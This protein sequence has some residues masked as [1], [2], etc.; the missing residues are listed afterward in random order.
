MENMWLTILL[1]WPLAVLIAALLNMLITW[2]FSWS[3][4]VLDY[5]AGVV[6]GLFF[7]FGLRGDAGIISE[8][9]LVLSTGLFGFLAAL[10]V[11]ALTRPLTLFFVSAGAMIGA[12]ALTAIFDRIATAMSWQS[13]GGAVAV[14]IPS[15]VLKAPFTC[16]TSTIGLLFCLVGA[17]RAAASPNGSIGFRGG[18][19]YVEWNNST[20]STSATTVGWTV[21]VWSGSMEHVFSHELYHSR[22]YIYLHDWLVPTW[23]VGGFW[24][25]ISSA[26]AGSF[27]IRSFQSARHN[28]EVGNPIEC[29]AYR[30]SGHSGF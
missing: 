8:I 21:Q 25:W 6:I 16:V 4:L 9:G 19:L 5:F 26:I 28:S 30:I 2:T 29:A 11:E 13:K 14:A 3:E 10:D 15:F 22:Q 1:Y 27:S 12:T 7:V 24:G 17:I 18:V 20:R 23:L